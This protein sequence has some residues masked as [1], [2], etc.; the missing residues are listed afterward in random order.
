MRPQMFAR[1]EVKS[2][3]H[4]DATLVPKDAVLFDPVTRKARVFVA[5]DKKAVEKEVKV[6]FSNPKLVEVTNGGV[7]T[8]DKVIVEGQTTLQDGDPIRVK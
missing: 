1:G 3:V 5:L 2:A 8:G 4:R 6:G 7:T